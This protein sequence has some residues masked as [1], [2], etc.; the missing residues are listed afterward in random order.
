[1]NE[2][3]AVEGE[4]L[5]EG[6]GSVVECGLF[7]KP[8]C[9]TSAAE[10]EVEGVGGAEVVGGGEIMDGGVVGYCVWGEGKEL[11]HDWGV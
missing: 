8:G 9:A 7:E 11:F 5:G 6:L 10:F 1:M 3:A 4:P 2:D